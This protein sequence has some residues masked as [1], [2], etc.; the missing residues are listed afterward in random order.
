MRPKW[1][2]FLTVAAVLAALVCIWF[3]TGNT[4]IQGDAIDRL[5]IS[6]IPRMDL[7]KETENP[8]DI[9]MFAG[10]WNQLPCYPSL[11]PLGN[12]TI[13]WF[14]FRTR[15]T[16]NVHR[17]FI[18]GSHTITFDN[19]PYYTPVDLGQWFPELYQS[20]EDVLEEPFSYE[21]SS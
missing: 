17:V 18:T 19:R 2:R 13:G 8:E 4:T 16:G 11:P 6:S 9:Q 5:V 7:Q 14:R 10:R 15:E 21:T 20:L 1:K 3:F 12:G